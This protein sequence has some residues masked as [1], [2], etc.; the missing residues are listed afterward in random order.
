VSRS[1]SIRRARRRRADAIKLDF[2]G[3]VDGTEFPGGA[4][5]GLHAR[6]RLGVVHPG[7]RGPDAS[8]PRFGKPVDVKVTFPADYGNTELAGKEAVFKC[9]IKEIHE[10]STSRPTMSWR[11][12]TTS[13]TSRRLRKAVGERIGQDYAR[14]SR[15][16]I[17][18]QAARQAGR[19]PQVR[20]PRRAGRRRVQC[21]L[22]AHRGGQKS[23]EKLEDDRGQDAQGIP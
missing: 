2:V 6:A 1:R 10:S 14:I 8:A 23:C 7:L 16:M 5:A 17:K 3:S 12:R 21:H 18:R 22:A 4:A 20:R 19:H 15:S 13:R 11:R 9:T